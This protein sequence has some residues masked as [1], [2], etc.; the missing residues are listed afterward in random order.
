[1]TTFTVLESITDEAILHV[2]EEAENLI[3]M[4]NDPEEETDEPVEEEQDEEEADGENES[5]QETEN[6]D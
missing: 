1:M 5:A 3:V 6:E 2:S 4:D